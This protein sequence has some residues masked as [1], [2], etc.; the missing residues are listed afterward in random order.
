VP[1]IGLQD[2][3]TGQNIQHSLLALLRQSIYGRL[4]GCEDV[5]DAERLGHD[6]VMRSVVGGRAKS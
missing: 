3:R 6:P 1:A 2:T 5:H 4:A